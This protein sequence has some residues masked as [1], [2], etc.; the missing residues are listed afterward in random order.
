MGTSQS[1]WPGLDEVISIGLGV[2][3]TTAVDMIFKVLLFSYATGRTLPDGIDTNP[4][5]DAFAGKS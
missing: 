1:L 5:R 3:A 4:Y 2:A